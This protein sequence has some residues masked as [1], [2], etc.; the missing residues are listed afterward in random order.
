[1]AKSRKDRIQGVLLSLATINDDDHNLL[2]DRQRVHLRWL[3][4]NGFKEG[5]GVLLIAGGMGEGYFLEDDEW[6][7]MVDLLAEEARGKVATG[8]GIFELSARRAASKARYAADAGIDCVQMAPPHYLLPSEQEVFDHY[9]YVNDAAD[10][11]IVAYNT[12]WAMPSPGFDFS[13]RLLEKFATL[14]NMVGIKWSTSDYRHY[15]RMIRLLGDRLNFFDN[16][17]IFTHGARV[18]S[19]GFTDFLGN[20]APRLAL[21][22][23]ELVSQGRFNECD[24][25]ELQLEFDPAAKESGAGEPPA[26]GMGEGPVARMIL[27]ALGMETGPA[28]PAQVS[29]PEAAVKAY[30]RF[31]Q[32]SGIRRQWVDWDQ[33][34]FDG[35][36]DGR[37]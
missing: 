32:A 13:Q 34:L 3:I 25:L 2:L 22:K 4:E 14:E 27:S 31:V 12:P 17:R 33:S 20:V 11:G 16:N 29:Q 28:F 21:K 24:D 1:M 15:L 7:N 6:R 37:R 8:V 26:G 30:T 19:K 23:W 5:S 35:L 36:S 18:G 10:I 9:R